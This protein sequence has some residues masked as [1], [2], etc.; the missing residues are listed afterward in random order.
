M[1]VD[2]CRGRRPGDRVASSATAERT[3]ASGNLPGSLAAADLDLEERILRAADTGDLEEFRRLAEQLGGVERAQ[4]LVRP[5]GVVVRPA[6]TPV[7]PT[8]ALSE[9]PR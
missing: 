9:P 2:A 7:K 6:A 3:A 1:S 5:R 8:F 4:A